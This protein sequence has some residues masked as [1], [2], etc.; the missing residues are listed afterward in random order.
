MSEQEYYDSKGRTIRTENVDG[1]NRMIVE[2]KA[3]ATQW[4][5]PQNMKSK[6]DL[7]SCIN[8]PRWASDP[9]FRAAIIDN[10]R[11]SHNAG[12]MNLGSSDE[13]QVLEKAMDGNSGQIEDSIAMQ[14]EGL[15][16]LFGDP[17]YSKSAS[18]RAY[19]MEQ[20]RLSDPR[21]METMPSFSYQAPAKITGKFAPEP[22]EESRK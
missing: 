17:R 3:D 7:Q 6:K 8:D 20:V 5:F 9:D 12:D 21:H 18:F 2:T 15:T 22:K 10:M 11:K 13:V 19:V 14:R 1:V 4:E 16:A